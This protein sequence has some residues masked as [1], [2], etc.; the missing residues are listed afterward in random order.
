MSTRKR[1]DI[2]DIFIT[3]IPNSFHNTNKNLLEPC[4]DHI[5]VLL[6]IDA[7]PSSQLRQASLTNGSMDWEKFREIVE[8][9]VK[10]KTRLKCPND[11]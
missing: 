3:F 9:K 10:L 5:S 1:P 8:Q 4:S 7:L 11:I 2:L 6:V